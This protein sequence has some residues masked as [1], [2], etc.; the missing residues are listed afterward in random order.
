MLLVKGGGGPNTRV[1]VCVCVCKYI[2]IWSDRRLGSW[3]V[4][5]LAGVYN[6]VSLWVVR[7]S[8]LVYPNAS[9]NRVGVW[10]Y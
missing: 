9:M 6:I 1:G 7:F 8:S 5:W 2:D 10:D 4:A 3:L